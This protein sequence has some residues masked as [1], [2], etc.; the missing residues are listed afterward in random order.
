MEKSKSSLSFA[1]STSLSPEAEMENAIWQEKYLVEDEYVWTLPEDLKEVARLEVG[2]T[3]EVRNEGLAYMRE[4]IR[5]DSRLTYCRRD[6]NFLLRFLRMKKF[7]L[8]AAKETLEKYLRMRA[9]I[10]EWYQNL[11]I[12]DPALNDIVSS[13]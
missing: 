6:A 12:N 3:E 9:E 11:D 7:N 13:G 10:P 1:S 2:E 5:E 8:E 4:F